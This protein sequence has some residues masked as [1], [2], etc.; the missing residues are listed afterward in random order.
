MVPLLDLEPF[1]KKEK[2]RLPRAD[3]WSELF[4]LEALKSAGVWELNRHDWQER[5]VVVEMKS[6][7][8]SMRLR[9]SDGWNN[10]RTTE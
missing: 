4:N 2:L 5:K 1:L 3:R 10:T 9:I 8:P 6:I 7:R